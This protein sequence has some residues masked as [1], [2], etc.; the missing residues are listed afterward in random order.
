MYSK[1]MPS[2][3]FLNIIIINY[4]D[5]NFNGHFAW[6]NLIDNSLYI[7]GTAQGHDLIVLFG[8]QSENEGFWEL[9]WGYE[10]L[11]QAL[12]KQR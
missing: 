10:E 8:H 2:F 11:K 3:P 4:F 1:W 7:E 12:P 6:L 9:D 5:Y